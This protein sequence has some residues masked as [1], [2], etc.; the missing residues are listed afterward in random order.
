MLTIPTIKLCDVNHSGSD[1][2]NGEKYQRRSQGKD[3]P[4]CVT[5]S[6]NTVKMRQQLQVEYPCVI[7]SN[8]GKHNVPR[9]SC[10]MHIIKQLPD[11]QP[12]IFVQRVSHKSYLSKDQKSLESFLRLDSKL[13]KNSRLDN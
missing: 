3:R 11:A 5:F 1:P 6:K 2:R 13:S 4:E 7:R 12:Q 10:A 8:Q 9:K